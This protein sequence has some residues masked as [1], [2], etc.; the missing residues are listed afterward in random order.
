MPKNTIIKIQPKIL[1]W[2]R[3]SMGMSKGIVIAHFNSSKSRQKY[4]IDDSF[5]K[6]LEDSQKEIEI[7]F[8]LLKEFAH[9]YRKPLSVF[10]IEK[11]VDDKF[12]P[13]DFRTLLSI[14]NYSISPETMLV[15]RRTRRVQEFVLEASNE[16]GY[17]I[18]FK[19]RK[20]TL[21]DDPKLLAKEIREKINFE[22]EHQKKLKYNKGL[23]DLLKDKIENL[24]V[25]VLRHTFP[26]DDARAFSIVD[27]EPYIIVLNNKDGDSGSYH[28]KIFSLLHEFCHILLRENTIDNDTINNYLHT[29]KFCN[30]FAGEFL[31]PKD[32]FYKEINLITK[33]YF[34]IKNI[35]KYVTKLVSV[36]KVSRQVILRKFLN[37][38]YINAEFYEEKINEWNRQYELM[39]ETKKK[40]IPPVP[41]EKKAFNNYGK[42]VAGILLSAENS[43]II[44]YNQVANILGLKTKYMPDFINLYMENV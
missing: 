39:K 26:I 24:G 19:F 3:Q 16:L 42:L 21:K 2:A 27:M 40:F 43:N 33:G 44:T 23:F 34:N 25:L 30:E 22:F 12:V 31:V 20:Y 37:I 15:I 10:F 14:S 6:N 32:E 11:P 1:I 18:K 28:S 38:N 17:N 4:N 13:K 29:E 9:L 36:F 35:D 7:S 5:L 41:Q 8:T